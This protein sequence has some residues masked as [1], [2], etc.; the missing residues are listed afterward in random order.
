MSVVEFQAALRKMGSDIVYHREQGGIECPCRAP[1]GYRDPSWHVRWQRALVLAE[2]VDVGTAQ[3]DGTT[4]VTYYVFA[5]DGYFTD[6]PV[7]TVVPAH[8]KSVKLVLA[9]EVFSGRTVTIGRQTYDSI[10][11]SADNTEPIYLVGT[12]T[13]GSLPFEIDDVWSL[14]LAGQT[15]PVGT[16]AT[17]NEQGFLADVV[18][19]VIKGS[20]QPAQTGYLRVSQRSNALLGEV[21]VGD[22]LGILPCVWDG[23]PLDLDRWS[24]A[25]EDYL[26]YDGRR[27]MVVSFDK[28]PDV[29]GSPNHHYECGLRLLSGARPT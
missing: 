28:L 7:V 17:C 29:D 20:I 10:A 12:F 3:F 22:K 2:Q 26:L 21:L 1:E 9:S 19:F 5:S 24:D 16:P 18:E 14:S 6:V 25:G 27:Y 8:G 15:L 4:G 11:Q 23:N 13:V